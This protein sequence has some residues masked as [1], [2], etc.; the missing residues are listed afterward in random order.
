[1]VPLSTG[2]L[3]QVV[4]NVSDG[5]LETVLG[6]A[7][8]HVVGFELAGQTGEVELG[9][10]AGQFGV[11]GARAREVGLFA[12]LKAVFSLEEHALFEVFVLIKG[13]LFIASWPRV[14]DSVDLVRQLSSATQLERPA[15][16]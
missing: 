14:V 7:R 8:H 3:G 1:M 6:R 13:R 10:A 5:A 11:V 9:G 16:G 12:S 2:R 15:L 4:W